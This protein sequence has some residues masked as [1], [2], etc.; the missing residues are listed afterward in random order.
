MWTTITHW[1]WKA[2][3]SANLHQAVIMS[4]TYFLLRSLIIGIPTLLECQWSLPLSYEDT[5]NHVQDIT[6]GRLVLVQQCW[7]WTLTVTAKQ[8]IVT[9]ITAAVRLPCVKFS[10]IHKIDKAQWMSWMNKPTNMHHH[11]TPQAKLW[12]PLS[13]G[14]ESWWLASQRNV[15]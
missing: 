10:W 12:G 1:N 11:S 6:I 15:V 8:L 7:P 9:F 2:L 4:H 14:L 5:L 3:K 13:A